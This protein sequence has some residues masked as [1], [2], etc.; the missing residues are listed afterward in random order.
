MIV[1]TPTLKSNNEESICVQEDTFDG[2]I[3]AKVKV[4]KLAICDMVFKIA[5]EVPLSFKITECKF[6]FHEKIKL[7]TRSLGN[8]PHPSGSH[9]KL[10]CVKLHCCKL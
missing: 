6:L 10:N 1:D 8:R 4:I 3:R 5:F 7:F 9:F 2:I